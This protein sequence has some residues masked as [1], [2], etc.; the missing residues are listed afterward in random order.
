MLKAYAQQRKRGLDKKWKTFP[1]TLICKNKFIENHRFLKIKNY[2]LVLSAMVQHTCPLSL[3]EKR[4][5][6]FKNGKQIYT[7]PQATQH[8]SLCRYNL[9]LCFLIHDQTAG[10]A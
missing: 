7:L 9:Q 2:N 8:C 1:Y 6:I 5:K 10:I 3:K 4:G